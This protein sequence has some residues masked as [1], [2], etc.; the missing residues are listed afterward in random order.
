MKKKRFIK[1]CMSCG[2]S[3]NDARI[4]AEHRKRCDEENAVKNHKLK[5]IG[6]P[7]RYMQKT[8]FIEFIDHPCTLNGAY[9]ING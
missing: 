7:A 6:Y 1:L 3:R 2:V 9:T 4:I 5:E 8:I